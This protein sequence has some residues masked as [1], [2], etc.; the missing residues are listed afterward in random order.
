MRKKK[1]RLEGGGEKEGGGGGE[2]SGS[3]LHRWSKMRKKCK[4][5][6]CACVAQ[7]GF[8]GVVTQIYIRTHVKASFLSL[9]FSPSTSNDDTKG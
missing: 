5:V 7:R 8:G 3:D 9:S 1:G 4:D 6:L 2:K